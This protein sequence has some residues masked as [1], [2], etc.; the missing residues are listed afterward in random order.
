MDSEKRKEPDGK[1]FVLF[2]MHCIEQDKGAAAA[3][4][5]ADTSSTDHQSWEHLVRFGVN[6]QN[7]NQRLSFGLI[8]AALVKGKVKR[9]GLLGIG[10]AIAKCYDKKAQS[11]QAKAKLR[12][13]L[14][15]D[16]IAELCSILRP[17]LRLIESKCT[18][19]LNYIRLL[20]EILHFELNNERTKAKWAQNFY[21]SDRCEE[22]DL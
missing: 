9:I 21:A 1:G 17:M 3:L 4:R 5:K 7:E 13:L 8:G 19:T 15:C 6:L 20:D 11:D 10:E 22:S 14:A 2:V 18:G 12:R 16:S